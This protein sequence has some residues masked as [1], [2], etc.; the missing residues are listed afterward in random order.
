MV[1]ARLERLVGLCGVQALGCSA[2]I[3]RRAAL[4]ERPIQRAGAR[5]GA[6]EDGRPFSSRRSAAGVCDPDVACHE[7]RRVSALDGWVFL[8]STPSRAERD[9]R[10]RRDSGGVTRR[11]RPHLR[12][13]AHRLISALRPERRPARSRTTLLASR[14]PQPGI[15]NHSARPTA[16]G[17]LLIRHRTAHVGRVLVLPHT[18]VDYLAEQVIIRP[19][20]VFDLDDEFGT[21]P[22]HAAQNEW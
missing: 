5:M 7:R 15:D 19:S 20:Q 2:R 11:V 21:Y 13:P 3:C 10:R 22:V 12:H 17:R 9:R 18:L 6:D 8:S 4:E 16:R 1:E 14:P